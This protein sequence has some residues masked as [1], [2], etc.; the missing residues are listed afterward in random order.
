MNNYTELKILFV[1][2]SLDRGGAQRQLSILAPELRN[3]G[4]RIVVSVGYENEYYETILRNHNIDLHVRRSGQRK[5]NRGTTTRIVHLVNDLLSLSRLTRNHRFDVIYSFG[6]T[7]NPY[8]AAIRPVSRTVTIWGIRESSVNKSSISRLVRGLLKGFADMTIVNS[9]AGR[10]SLVESGISEEKIEVIENGIDTEKFRINRVAG[11]AIRKRLGWD[12]DAYVVGIVAR[13]DP[14]KDH[15]TFLLA[16]ARAAAERRGLKAIV[17]GEGASE[18]YYQ[19]RQ[20]AETLGID[21]NIHWAG[22]QANAEDYINAMDV[23]V[24]CSISEGFPNVAVESLACGVPCIVT[25]VGDS[26]RIVNDRARIVP[27]GE[28]ELLSEAILRTADCASSIDKEELRSQVIDHWGVTKMADHTEKLIEDM[29]RR[30][31]CDNVDRPL[32][33]VLHVV[34]ALNRGGTES[35][36]MAL[37]RQFLEKGDIENHIVVQ[38]ESG[39]EGYD[40]DARELG[41]GIHHIPRNLL[42]P[43]EFYRFLRS[44][45]RFDVVHSHRNEFSV[46]VL[47]IALLAGVPIRIAHSHNDHT[48]NEAFV[49]YW[50]RK[51]SSILLRLVASDRVA[52]SREAQVSLFG[53]S[54]SGSRIIHCGIATDEYRF[55]QKEREETRRQLG[56]ISRDPVLIHV[57]GL[58]EQK[59]HKFLLEVFREYRESFGP[60]AVLLLVGGGPLGPSLRKLARELGIEDSVKFLGVQPD[61]S[62]FLAAAD[63][64]V[65]PSFHEGLS[66]ALLE[67]QA[68]GIPVVASATISDEGVVNRDY[69]VS[70]DLNDS[71]TEWAISID[72]CYRNGRQYDDVLIRESM[73]SFD[74][75]T[76]ACLVKQIYAGNASSS[77][78]A[79]Y[80]AKQ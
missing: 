2:S 7:T 54:S 8:V 55:D 78:G 27:P 41:V 57:G 14:V 43:I 47:S 79:D 1:V 44:Q 60:T 18:R 56:L 12:D 15:E 52:V 67:A 13:L 75:A 61:V 71:V 48:Q 4:H 73:R 80:E 62:R 5:R 63:V 24:L 11:D 50:I 64:F 26:A 51:S 49:S 46:L 65:F 59:N 22:V 25:D 30:N 74:I 28:V 36:L 77:D 66:I 42:W 21:A 19:L 35:W 9:E 17:L 3:R 70:L 20:L 53:A 10:I 68:S 58:K 40:E 69:Y 39:P 34:G 45:P 33:R 76:S 29:L 23:T 38:Q 37:S 6:A 16:F 72:K 32:T 31:A